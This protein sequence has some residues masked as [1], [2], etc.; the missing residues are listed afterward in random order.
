MKHPIQ[1]VRDMITK[2]FTMNKSDYIFQL[3]AYHGYTKEQLEG[4]S[5]AELRQLLNQLNAR[6]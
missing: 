5:L 4:K 1:L 2:D 6:R 3:R